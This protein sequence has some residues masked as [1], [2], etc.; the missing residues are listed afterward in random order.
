MKTLF[1]TLTF[2]LSTY[3]LHGQTTADL[4]ITNVQ[5][6]GTGGLTMLIDVEIKAGSA[7]TLG[8]DADFTDLR[9]TID[10]YGTG[11]G[12]MVWNRSLN[13]PSGYA[14][15]ES[16]KTSANPR[17]RFALDGGSFGITTS[18]QRL[19]TLEFTLGT[20]TTSADNFDVTINGA[21]KI[22]DNSDVEQTDGGFT[23]LTNQALPIVL[24]GFTAMRLAN[25]QAKLEWA[26]ATETN[27]S[28]FEIQR[29]VDG[30]HFENIGFVAGAGNSINE[31]HY[32]Y[33]D[34][35]A[36]TLATQVLYYRLK[37]IDFNGDYSYSPVQSIQQGIGM[38]ISW[39]PNPASSHITL[40]EPGIIAEI[41]DLSGRVQVRTDG[42]IQTIGLDGLLPGVYLLR[43]RRLDGSVLH[44]DRLVKQ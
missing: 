38:R 12:Q 8:G 31:L 36:A 33:T 41:V 24:S 28:G 29:S 25:G 11:Q 26:T 20:G 30:Q 17:L 2:L 7:F 1:S 16:G 13:D 10:N 18:W 43:L 4:R 3:I 37:Q 22:F 6:T 19:T 5:F 27:N 40:A 15:L 23:G 44:Q 34:M 9:F 14:K 42:N 32:S 21:T 39:Q 35:E